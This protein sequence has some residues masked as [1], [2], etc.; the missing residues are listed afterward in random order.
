M[1]RGRGNLEFWTKSFL[2]IQKAWRFV[3]LPPWLVL[4]ILLLESIQ[5][6][7]KMSVMIFYP[8]SS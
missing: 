7:G 2:E 6:H 4:N 5:H 3:E 1:R 8:S